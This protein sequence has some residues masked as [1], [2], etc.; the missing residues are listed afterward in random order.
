M[1]EGDGFGAF[2]FGVAVSKLT[3]VI[4][5][6]E[7]IAKRQ[8]AHTD[9]ISAIESK[10]TL[11]KGAVFGLLIG[12]GFMLYGVKQTLVTIAKQFIG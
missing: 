11:G 9:R 7:D 3:A 12:L 1:S 4:E 5:R 6:I 8:E 10:F 2:E